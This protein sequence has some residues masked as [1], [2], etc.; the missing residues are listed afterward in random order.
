MTRL[1]QLGQLSQALRRVE[2]DARR[3]NRAVGG[4]GS[5]PGVTGASSAAQGVNLGPIAS[6]L[7]LIERQTRTEPAQRVFRRLG[8]P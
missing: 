8:L 5:G 6:Q 2:R 7:A 4:V 3:A 1:E